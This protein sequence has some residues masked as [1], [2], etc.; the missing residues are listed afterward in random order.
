MTTYFNGSKAKELYYD[1][2]KIKEAWYNGEK[3]YSSSISFSI[4]GTYGT[5]SWRWFALPKTL[6]SGQS[7]T[8]T[9]LIRDT[10]THRLRLCKGESADTSQMYELTSNGTFTANRD[11][12]TIYMSIGRNNVHVRVTITY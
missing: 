7:F 4:D 11:Y 2:S 8:I 1:G 12:D 6:K 10:S 3:V 5:S 9:N